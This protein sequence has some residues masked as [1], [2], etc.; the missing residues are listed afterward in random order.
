MKKLFFLG[1]LFA[2]GLSFT[3]CSDKD[4]VGTEVQQGENGGNNYIAISINLPTDRVNMSRADDNA[5]TITFDDGLDTEY[6]VKDATLLVFDKTSQYF[7]KAY[8]L[9]KDGFTKDGT[10]KQVTSHG[11]KIIQMVGTSVVAGDLAL[12]VLNNNDLFT[13][14]GNNIVFGE[15]P[16]SGTYSQ[17]QAKTATTT[18]LDASSMMGSGK[19]FYMANAPLSDKQGS[20]TTAPTG[21]AVQVLVPITTVYKTYAEAEAGAADQIYVE[22]GMA[23]VTM[24]KTIGTTTMQNS[25]V[26]NQNLTA[27]LDGWTL[28]NCNP[29]SYLVRSTDGYAGFVTLKSVATGGVYRYIGNSQI[30]Y[31]TIPSY[32]Y[33]TYFA[34]SHGYDAAKTLNRV[35]APTYYAA[36]D[37][38]VVAGTKEIG[39]LKT[40]GT[41]F[42]TDFGNT[43][44]QYCFENTFPVS[45]QVVNNTTLVQ[46]KVTAKTGS[47][48]EDLY[49]A[50]GNKTNIY[51]ETT[52]KE[53]I[54][55]AAYDYVV[56]QNWVKEGTFS[57]KDITVNLTKVNSATNEVTAVTISYN[58]TT[59][60]SEGDATLKAGAFTEDVEGTSGTFV[61][62][63]NTTALQAVGTVLKYVGGVSYYHIR[64]KHFGD[65]LTPWNNGEYGSTAPSGNTTGTIYPANGSN[66]DNN[67]LGR[68]GV[69]R[70]NWYDLKINKI[71]YLGDAV[72]KTGNW[73]GTPD[74]E[75]DNYITFQINVLSWAKHVTQ[76]ADL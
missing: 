71:N 26:G 53:L 70:N 5:G 44:P 2:V 35:L 76:E 67:Y 69:L 64:I 6:E 10:D 60:T 33:R 59:N 17:F 39:N 50:G 27:T 9:S 15:E 57:S 31:P 16:F 7:K 28:D 48:P 51:T 47:T 11:T 24:N 62:N 54:A 72:P 34:K 58:T 40:P 75:L 14:S 21:A 68:Y 63:V 73:P 43:N 4:D 22:R 32:P 74:D 36:G 30:T 8:S 55:S 25:K 42:S 37:E 19:G 23:K 46:L 41:S 45:L 29:N 56:S 18:G 3:A 49:T 12:V 65:A 66:Q 61:A 52:I 13:L 38:E 20:T 1:A